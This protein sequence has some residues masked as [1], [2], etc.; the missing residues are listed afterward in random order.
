MSNVVRQKGTGDGVIENVELKRQLRAM[1]AKSI[2][3]ERCC[4]SNSKELISCPQGNDA[5]A[6]DRGMAAYGLPPV[7]DQPFGA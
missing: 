4:Q 1:L 2:C 5:S 7:P 3:S 6:H